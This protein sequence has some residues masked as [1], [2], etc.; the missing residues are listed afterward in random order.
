VPAAVVVGIVH[1]LGSII[2]QAVARV[3]AWWPKLDGGWVTAF[4]I[5]VGTLASFL[6]S[7]RVASAINELV[8]SAVGSQ[9]TLRALPEAVEYLIAGTWIALRAGFLADQQAA[10]TLTLPVVG[11]D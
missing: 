2:K 11:Q 6:F 10:S 9:I 3:R 8:S 1:A 4:A 7:L 5:G